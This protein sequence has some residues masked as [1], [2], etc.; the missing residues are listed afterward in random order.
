MLFSP[1]SRNLNLT[2]HEL[3]LMALKQKTESLV[4]AYDMEVFN[5]KITEPIQSEVLRL[6]G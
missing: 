3:I 4:D 6:I 2:T 5:P 1:R